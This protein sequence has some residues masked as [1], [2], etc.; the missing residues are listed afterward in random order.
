MLFCTLLS[1]CLALSAQGAE[2]GNFTPGRNL[3]IDYKQVTK[4]G[5]GVVEQ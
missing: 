2:I 4:K 3:A 1:H 5:G